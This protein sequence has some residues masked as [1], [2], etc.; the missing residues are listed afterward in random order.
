[1][2]LIKLPPRSLL[3]LGTYSEY[4]NHNVKSIEARWLLQHSSLNCHFSSCSNQSR[5]T[6]CLV[7]H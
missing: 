1:M 4:Q 6:R 2:S 7:R 3:Q 5:R